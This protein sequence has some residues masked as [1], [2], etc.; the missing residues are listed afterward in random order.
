LKESVSED[1]LVFLPPSSLFFYIY[2]YIYIENIVLLSVGDSIL[3]GA[4]DS[5]PSSAE[6]NFLF[7]RKKPDV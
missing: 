7:P 5:T 4:L 1:V 2:I 3:R 6:I